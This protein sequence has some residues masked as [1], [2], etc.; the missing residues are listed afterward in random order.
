MR[1]RSRLLFVQDGLLEERVQTV[2]SGETLSEGRAGGGQL[3][4]EVCFPSGAVS[5]RRSTIDGRQ[6]A[7]RSGLT[8]LRTGTAREC[9]HCGGGG[10]EVC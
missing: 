5:V 9:S 6:Y 10:E 4:A 8:R 1:Y 7:Q 3:I 2:G